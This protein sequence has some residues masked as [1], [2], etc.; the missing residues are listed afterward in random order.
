MKIAILALYRSSLLEKL[1]VSAEKRFYDSVR[2]YDSIERAKKDI[3]GFYKK[4]RSRTNIAGLI[5]FE[6]DRT[7]NDIALDF[8]RRFSDGIHIF[9]NG[10]ARVDIPQ[11]QR[12]IITQAFV[13]Y[14]TKR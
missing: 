5:N 4:K 8:S 13:E 10:C 3:E 14:F 12:P 9:Y 6:D 2:L 7:L 11:S 1:S